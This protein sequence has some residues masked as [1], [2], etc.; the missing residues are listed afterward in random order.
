M[1]RMGRPDCPTLHFTLIK[2]MSEDSDCDDDASISI[3]ILVSRMGTCKNNPK[4]WN[5][6]KN[7]KNPL[8]GELKHNPIFS[9]VESEEESDWSNWNINPSFWLV[10]SPAWQTFPLSVAVSQHSDRDVC[11]HRPGHH[12]YDQNDD[13]HNKCDVDTQQVWWWWSQPRW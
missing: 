12:V 7:H 9:L 4:V 2:M 10:E 8:I 1:S 6:R 13:T 11:R 3:S 5:W